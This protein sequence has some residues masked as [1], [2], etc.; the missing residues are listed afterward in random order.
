MKT[1]PHETLSDD[2]LGEI[3]ARLGEID[4]RWTEWDREL[5][6]VQKDLEEGGMDFWD[7]LHAVHAQQVESMRRGDSPFDF[8]QLRQLL[9]ELCG[10]YL[11]AD[12][13]RRALIRGFFDDKDRLSTY[14]HSY[15]GGRA[16]RLLRSSGDVKWLRIGLAAASISDMRVDWRDLLISL[17]KLYLA[18]EDV[19]I[20]PISHFTAVA[21]ISNP[22]GRYGEGSTRDLLRDFHRSGHLRSIKQQRQGNK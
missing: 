22:E 6:Q 9:D 12:P 4:A 13:E 15:I 20:R 16:A 8:D 17:G 19:G 10:I 3:D 11:E 18:A 21:K 14:L 7:A 2:R 1:T 5:A